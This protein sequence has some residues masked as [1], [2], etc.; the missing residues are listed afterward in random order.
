[1][2]VIL[3]QNVNKIGRKNEIKVVSDGYAM[4][5]LIPRKLAEVATDGAVKRSQEMLAQS[6]AIHQINEDL[7]I[8]N[9]KDLE[10]VRIEMSE[11]ANDKGHL[12]A[13]IHAE[14]LV[15]VIKE[16]TRLDIL[17]E[18]ILLEKPIKTVGEHKI[19]IKI[20]DSTVSFTLIV[21]PVK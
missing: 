13:G 8:K 3:L 6:E 16:Q 11:S 7:L 19:G 18:H 9:L 17:P 20:Q 5:F 21:H 1:M 2:K 10:G 12:F 14:E 15:P 4:N